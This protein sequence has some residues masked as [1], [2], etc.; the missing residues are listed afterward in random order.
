MLLRKTAV[1]HSFFC[2]VVLSGHVSGAPS[3]RRQCSLRPNSERDTY[4]PSVAFRRHLPPNSARIGC[5]AERHSLSRL[6]K[7]WILS[8]NP[9]LIYIH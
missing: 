1:S 9:M 3:L 2:K 7:V 8:S 4:T 6:Q 5:F